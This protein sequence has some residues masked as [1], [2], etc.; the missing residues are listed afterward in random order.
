MQLISASRLHRPE[1]PVTFRRKVKSLRCA[2]YDW[3]RSFSD[4]GSLRRCWLQV[5]PTIVEQMLQM[6]RASDGNELVQKKI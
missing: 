1:T 6:L 5:T 4:W 3:S 2:A